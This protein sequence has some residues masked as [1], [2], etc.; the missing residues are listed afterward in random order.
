MLPRFLDNHFLLK[1][2]AHKNFLIIR[3]E[4]MSV[5][6]GSILALHHETSTTKTKFILQHLFDL[7]VRVKYFLLDKFKTTENIEESKFYLIISP[8]YNFVELNSVVSLSS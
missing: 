8:V 5:V 3:R 6:P 4:K 7:I 1:L 2:V